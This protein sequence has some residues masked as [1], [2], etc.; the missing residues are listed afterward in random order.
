LS[1]RLFPF[2]PHDAE[3]EGSQETL[4]RHAQAHG[5]RRVG[6][7]AGVAERQDDFELS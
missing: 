5:Q 6:R 1:I 2:D 7:P 3:A 4:D